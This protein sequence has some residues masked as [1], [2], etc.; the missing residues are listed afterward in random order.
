MRRRETSFGTARGNQPGDQLANRLFSTA[1]ALALGMAIFGAT[2]QSAYAEKCVTGVTTT[3]N[4]NALTN[5]TGNTT[6]VT[7][8]PALAG[9]AAAVIDETFTHKVDGV[10]DAS[11]DTL[12]VAIVGALSTNPLVSVDL[13]HTTA[14]FVNS[15]PGPV[16]A[17]T[18]LSLT[19]APVVDTVTAQFSGADDGGV[20]TNTA[21]GL[22][23]VAT[24][25]NASAFGADS[26]AT[27]AGA[28]AVGG[29]AQATG[30]GS[31]A[32]GADPGAGLT[33]A[34]AFG[35]GSTVV[36]ANSTANGTFDAIL[37]V[38]NSTGA[39]GFNTVVGN[40]ITIQ[41]GGFNNTVLGVGHTVNG[42]GNF[43]AGDPNTVAGNNNVVTGDDNAVTGNNNVVSGNNASVTG[44]QSVAIGENGTVDS[45][46]N[47]LAI[48]TNA[49]TDE[50][51]GIAIGTEATATGLQSMAIGA[52]SS[53]TQ[54]KATAIGNNADATQALAT[55][56]G[57]DAQVNSAN[58]TAAGQGAVINAG[59]A[60]SAAFGQG[61][62]VAA[63]SPNSSSFGQGAQAN[64]INATAVG[65]GAQ[66][67]AAGSAAF[68][69]GA[70]ASLSNQQVFGTSSSTYTTP[71]I[72]SAQSRSRQSGPL[73][74][75]TTDANGNLASDGGEIF[76]RLDEA[77]SGIAMSIAM[78]NPD[79]VAGERFG[80]AMNAGFYEG[81]EAMAV[82]AQGVV[83]YNVFGD[84]D[85]FAVSGGVGV[86][87]GNDRGQEVVGGRVGAQ[88]T[89]R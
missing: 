3:S 41:G 54:T 37:G 85:R 21:C 89:W 31:T 50:D 5:V 79:L 80:V 75:V 29:G 22:N 28:T 88:L 30:F 16:Q 77:E 15:L 84:G 66:A 32:I 59:S 20:A 62:T 7:G 33:A 58:G 63:N 45:A 25:G 17:V 46:N 81:A 2:S 69:Q 40:G 73:E 1:S 78:Q 12:D 76:K 48:G 42:S 55:A 52:N 36:G 4:I 47:A 23:A 43:V 10:P 70:V 57:A 56:I 9:F 13:T 19:S 6:A 51:D 27:D 38:N 64:A 49:N 82:S 61:A 39:G 68:G 44:N 72:T 34:Q 14:N 35:L 67:N 26:D 11:S 86:G 65:Q 74:V 18:S 60:N 83:G 8:N 71:G 53:A 87:F 24:G